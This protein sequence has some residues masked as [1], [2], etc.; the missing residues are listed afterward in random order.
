M[1]DADKTRMIEL[2]C[3]EETMTISIA[4]IPERNGR[5]ERRTERR[6]DRVAISI[7]RVNVLTRDNLMCRLPSKSTKLQV[8]RI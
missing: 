7:S 6:T 4:Y 5:M 2:S 1:F 3:G 8:N